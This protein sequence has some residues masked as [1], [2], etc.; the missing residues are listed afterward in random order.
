MHIFFRM[1]LVALC[2][3]FAAP[4]QADDIV[5]V[6]EQNFP[7]QEVDRFY[8]ATKIEE[9]RCQEGT[10]FLISEGDSTTGAKMDIAARIHERI[11]SLGANGLVITDLTEDSRVRRIMVTP[12]T[13]DLR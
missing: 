2:A 7:Y 12:L 5:S 9:R 11:R 8:G 10:P 3:A 6:V 13:C 4:V 1:F